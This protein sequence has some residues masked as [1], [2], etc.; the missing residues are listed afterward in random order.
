MIARRR[1]RFLQLLAA[2]LRDRAIDMSP[3]TLWCGKIDNGGA[4]TLTHDRRDERPGTKRPD[5]DSPGSSARARARASV[6]RFS[7]RENRQSVQNWPAGLLCVSVAS[8]TP[9][10]SSEVKWILR[11]CTTDRTGDDDS[12]DAR[13]LHPPRG[14]ESIATLSVGVRTRMGGKGGIGG[15]WVMR[16]EAS[17]STGGG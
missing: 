12:H 14:E 7:C 16:E 6:A 17:G 15:G 13:R 4:R 3:R 1:R 11:A 2:P 5:L 10:V 9:R 8:P